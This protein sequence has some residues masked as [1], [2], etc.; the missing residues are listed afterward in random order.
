MFGLRT[1]HLAAATAYLAMVAAENIQVNVKNPAVNCVEGCND[2]VGAVTFADTDPEA[3]YYAARCGS[4][5]FSESLAL[6]S[7]TY[8]TPSEQEKGWALVQHYCEEYGM[9][10]I[11]S[12]EHFMGMIDMGNVTR[13]VSVIDPM[14]TGTMF[15][16]TILVDVLSWQTGV[17]TENAWTQQEIDHH[18]FGWA[19]Y[20]LLGCAVLVGGLNRLF[21]F[22]VQRHAH[23]SSEAASIPAPRGTRSKWY[24]MYRKHVEVPAMFGYKHSQASAWGWLSVPTRVQGIFIFLYVAL[25]VVFTCV[26]YDV[27]DLNMYWPGDKHLQLVRYVADRTGIMAFYN[28]PLLWCLAGRNDVILWITGWSYSSLN[29][30][31]RWVSRVTVAQAI[32]HS[33]AYTW[34]ERKYLA[35]SFKERYW[36]TGVVAT[37]LMSLMVPLSVRPFRE[38]YYEI[39]LIIHILFAIGSLVILWYH[40]FIMDGEYDPWIWAT[41]AV[42]ALDRFV[43]VCRV[44]VLTHKAL[45]RSGKNTVA[46]MSTVG[47]TGLIR[48][49]VETSIRVQPK[50]G[51]YYFLYTPLSIKPWENHPF[52]LASWQINERSTTLHFLVAPMKG[53]TKRWQKKVVGRGER[54]AEMRLLLEGP[55][56]SSHPVEMYD[57]VLFVAGGSGIT[58]S[59]P[60]LFRLRQIAAEVPEPITRDIT[61]VWIVKDRD[62]AADVLGHELREFIQD[63]STSGFTLRIKMYI[64]KEDGATPANV[65][66][67]LTYSNDPSQP[68]SQSFHDSPQST[69]TGTMEK[70]PSSDSGSDSELD[71]TQKPNGHIVSTQSPVLT[72]TPGRPRIADLIT[73]CAGR[74]IGGERL[75]VSA[76]GPAGLMDDARRAVCELYGEEE[77]QVAGR[78]VEYFEEL[79]SW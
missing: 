64:T 7:V 74:L 19:I 57:R 48:L 71:L 60:Y 34:L 15:N 55:Y 40:V 77:G 12:L 45:G 26:G 29:L 73:E 49:S 16:N 68:T 24:T 14:V 37:V 13:D 30:L 2:A 53:A 39:F 10:E 17:H 59:L 32:I 38:R 51:E 65:V 43:R 23:Y 79:F 56:G 11:G 41:V 28:L 62:Y 6:C 27:F 22:Y 35:E 47:D 54:T 67:T 42:W 3:G 72:L 70:Q 1:L 20:I 36:V 63:A 46:T 31:H 66:D 21:A 76:C 9:T 4:Q 50:A 33:A 25:N 8:C 69:S 44:L 18:A 61:L 52:T 58:S 78:T 75:A 5:M